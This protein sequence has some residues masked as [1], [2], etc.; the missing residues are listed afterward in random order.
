[1]KQALIVGLII[2]SSTI[3]CK[4]TAWR[5]EKD[6]KILLKFPATW[7]YLKES[8]NELIR[9]TIT[10]DSLKPLAIK[11][12]ELFKVKRNGRTFEFFK[13]NFDYS[14]KS[15]ME[16]KVQIS[17]EENIVF[18]GLETVYAEAIEDGIP[19]K[20]YCINGGDEVYMITLLERNHEGVWDTQMRKDEQAILNSMT[21][22][23]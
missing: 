13:D 14:L 19:A 5:F 4:R 11:A 22:D 16:G 9:I 15:R 17:K 23:E 2:C 1:M 8:R 21:I 10:P 7:Y 20:L 18:K 12:F 6:E 3:F